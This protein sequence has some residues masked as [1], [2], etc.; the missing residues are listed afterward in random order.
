VTSEEIQAHEAQVRETVGGDYTVLSSGI[1]C[2]RDGLSRRIFRVQ[3]PAGQAWVT[4]G[5]DSFTVEK[6]NTVP[7]DH[8]DGGR[9]GD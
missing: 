7:A 4:V 9:R 2:A 8:P 1:A 6:I 5:A 3:G